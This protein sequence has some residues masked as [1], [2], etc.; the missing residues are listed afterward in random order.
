MYPVK[1]RIL[2]MTMRIT[3]HEDDNEASADDKN[4]KD[5]RNT[6][7]LVNACAGARGSLAQR[8]VRRA[9]ARGRAT[10]TLR[11]VHSQTSKAILLLMLGVG[12]HR[13]RDEIYMSNVGAAICASTCI[14]AMY[15]AGT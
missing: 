13:V 12:M 3:T 6:R 2:A 10:T 15:E 8:A 1:F 7:R 4:K 9:Q 5:C 14:R 11:Q